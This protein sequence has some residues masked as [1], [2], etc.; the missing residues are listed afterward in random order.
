MSKT[1]LNRRTVLKAMGT[2]P[3]LAAAPQAVRAMN[4]SDVIV[5]GA[6]LSGLN[7]ALMLQ[8]EGLD[9]RV[10]EGRNRIGGRMQCPFS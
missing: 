5:I 10:L 1:K 8:G 2:A 7:S 3:I 4:E 6:G 9:V